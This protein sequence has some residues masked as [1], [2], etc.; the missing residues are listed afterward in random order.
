VCLGT[1]VLGSKDS[2]A[3]KAAVI[4]DT[5]GD[6]FKDTSSSALNILNSKSCFGG[7]EVIRY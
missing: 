6:P 7:V 5:V 4:G 1:E 3:H 2:V